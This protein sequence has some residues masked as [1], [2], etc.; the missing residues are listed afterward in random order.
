[1]LFK[2]DTLFIAEFESISD[3]WSLS[4]SLLLMLLSFLFLFKSLIWWLSLDV[5]FFGK[6]LISRLTWV[7]FCLVSVCCLL[8]ANSD[9]FLLIWPLCNIS[10]ISKLSL[11]VLF[12]SSSN[13]WGSPLFAITSFSLAAI[14]LWVLSSSNVAF[15][16][17]FVNSS[18]CATESSNDFNLSSGL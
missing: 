10:S 12:N 6:L 9:Y 17:F 16:K 1:M 11:W 14:S 4:L 15:L 18:I 7:S 8:I 5:S 3:F 2:F 13:W